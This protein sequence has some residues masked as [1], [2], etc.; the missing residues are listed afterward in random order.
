MTSRVILIAELDD[1]AALGCGEY[2]DL[3]AIADQTIE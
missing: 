3:V 1:A 2:N